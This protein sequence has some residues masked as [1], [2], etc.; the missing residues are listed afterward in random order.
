LERLSDAVANGHR[1][2]GV[3][4]GSAVNQDG[5]SNGL[6]APNGP[7]QQR[8]IRQALANAGL[9]AGDVD[10]V[11]AHGTGTTL[12]DPIEA[13][14][15]L[16]TYGQDR[17]EGR[18]L[19]L[20]SVK[21]NIGHTQAAAGVAGVIKMVMA[22][23]HGLMPETLHVDAP[24][25]HVDWS[26]GDVRLLT[27]AVAWPEEE[28]VR[29]A[30]VS[31]FGV[32]GT[33]AHVILEEA[34]AVTPAPTPAPAPGADPYG[35][36]P[37]VVSGRDAAGVRRQAARLAEFV[38]GR[39]AEGPA[40]RE[41][42][43]GVAA[44]LAGRAALEQRA[45]VVG[46]D[47]D[48][49]LAG[50]DALASAERSLPARTD[51][52]VVFVFPGQGGQW[53]GM[54][55]ELLGTWPVFAERMEVCERALAPFVD[56]SLREVL[57]GADEEWAGRVDV[58]QPVLWAVMVSLAEAWRAAGV[59]PEAVIGHSQGEIA[60]AVVAGRLSVEDGARV[61]AL[62]SQ[63]LRRLA[64]HG[65]MASVAL[66]AEKAEPHLL[67]G[68]TVAAVNA[69]GQI[70]VS[71]P[72]EEIAAL[73]A[74]WEEQGIRARRIEVD[75]A[76]HHAQVEEIAGELRAGLDGL[77]SR[78][79]QVAMWSTITGEL[80][81]D[82]ELDAGYWYRNLRQPVLFADAVRL[83]EEAGP[84][85]FVEIGPHPVLSLAMEQ[86]VTDGRVL[87][88]LRRRRP[89]TTQLL[90]SL[91]AAWTAGLPV[92]WRNLL[93][94]VRPVTPPTYAFQRQRYWLDAPVPSAASAEADVA[95]A[96]LT[97]T[98]H[99]LLTAVAVLPGDDARLFVGR[100]APHTHGWL[101][102][103]T[104]TGTVVVPSA[105]VA[106]AALHAGRSVR[107]P[108]LAHLTLVEPLAFAVD[109]EVQVQLV[110]GGPDD[111]GNRQVD[112]YSRPADDPDAAWRS[113][114]TGLLAAHQV[115]APAPAVTSWPPADA[116]PIA[117]DHVRR[118][119]DEGGYDTEDVLARIGRLWRSGTDVLA[120]GRIPAGEE[121]ARDRFTHALLQAVVALTTGPV[122][123]LT[124][125][126]V[127]GLATE[128]APGLATEAVP[129]LATER[130]LER[131]TE[132]F[133]APR[134]ATRWRD[135]VADPGFTGD[136][137]VRVAPTGPDTLSL[138]L[139]GTDGVPVADVGEVT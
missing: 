133:P 11:E 139:T 31:S 103:Y 90:T 109:E 98:D 69:P 97:P 126:P 9:S 45:V 44:G 100:L 12:G 129:G 37:W 92:A 5:A 79:S 112:L 42:I 38:R 25:P 28:R 110:V 84:T 116:E 15:L 137:R 134:L 99:P 10:V 48:E 13:Q 34:P 29:R 66:D 136:V 19:W 56:W 43:A 49:L 46:T 32:S 83:A 35:P 74:Q 132:A 70:V 104:T 115:G 1:V 125:E 138:H 62:R 75:Y 81:A 88:T 91:G 128:A 24:S 51:S 82:E 22:M 41:W 16:A 17:P 47:A 122:A 76:S 73:C 58:V 57:T 40:D 65:A 105:V 52:G 50:L 127:P 71:G 94:A 107:S 117:E 63:A 67:P 60:A 101:K 61:V 78:G 36:V 95:A 130:A 53:V 7:S 106:E 85:A 123:A 120:E 23:R 87:H 77:S 39:R 6:T 20:G 54:G 131:A 8:V 26:A 14:A 96:G 59:V 111:E 121:L 55:R 80:V 135:V 33:N 119:L 113:H 108:R 68:V 18:P 30:G 2:L 89:E 21:S 64:G 4:R 27:E 93:P 114:A 72:P 118:A 102:Q 124:A 86:T 3:L